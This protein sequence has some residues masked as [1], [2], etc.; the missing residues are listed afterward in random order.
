MKE[1]E[2]LTHLFCVV[3]SIH[4]YWFV[5]WLDVSKCWRNKNATT[6]QM[7]SV[8]ILEAEEWKGWGPSG[9]WQETFRL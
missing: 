1:L 4:H 2:G 5:I 3:M 7:R 6:S 8:G 9:G